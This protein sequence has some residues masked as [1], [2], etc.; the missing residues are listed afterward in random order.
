M[1]FSTWCK[2]SVAE[3]E[4]CDQTKKKT[5]AY[6]ELKPIIKATNLTVTKFGSGMVIISVSIYSDKQGLPQRANREANNNTATCPIH[7]MP[8]SLKKKSWQKLQI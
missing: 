4:R 1:S 5:T 8:I 2:S 3:T 7:S 6:A